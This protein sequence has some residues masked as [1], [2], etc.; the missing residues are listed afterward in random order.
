MAAKSGRSFK[1]KRGTSAN[2][3]TAQGG[4]ASEITLAVGASASDDAYNGA[5]VYIASG[6]GVG[7]WNIITDYVGATKVA[8]VGRAWDVE[9]TS[10]SAYVVYTQDVIAG[11]RTK[12][13]TI[14]AEGIDV[15]TDDELGWRTLL[16][17]PS[18]RS[19]DL[20]VE[21]VTKDDELR[22]AALATGLQPVSI[23]SIEYPDGSHLLGDFYLASLEE[24]GEYTDALTFS[25]S[26]QS[27]G[28]VYYV[29]AA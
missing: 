10:A 9:P 11:V 5:A 8:T 22:A 29:P 4:G 26:L 23:V 20:S 14:N 6:P 19:V 18:S 21:G 15:T 2:T 3:G 13:A 1:V 16:R 27:S 7:E 12:G 25:A 17:D 28:I 24:T